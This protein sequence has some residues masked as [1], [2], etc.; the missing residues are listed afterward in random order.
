MYCICTIWSSYLCYSIL[1]DQ[2]QTHD[3]CW[4]IDVKVVMV[5]QMNAALHFLS[6]GPWIQDFNQEC[7]CADACVLTFV[8]AHVLWPMLQASLQ[9]LAKTQIPCRH[10][11]HL[12]RTYILCWK[13]LRHFKWNLKC[14]GL[15]TIRKHLPCK[16]VGIMYKANDS[17][18]GL[19]AVKHF[20]TQTIWCKMRTPW[21]SGW[22]SLN[23]KK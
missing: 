17:E 3:F 10:V 2:N 23:Q 12:Q 20:A 22:I 11:F 7:K 6:H 18:T 15:C 9:S 21:N 16:N 4:N 1:V 13:G 14:P 19:Q 8:L 5:E